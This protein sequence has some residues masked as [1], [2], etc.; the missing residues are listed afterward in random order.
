MAKKNVV[1]ISP[2]KAMQQLVEKN[3]ETLLVKLDPGM[4]EKKFRKKIK[5][6]G[7]IL[8]KGIKVKK[9]K[10]KTVATEP[11]ETAPSA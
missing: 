4:A 1:K 7:K 6:A 9:E 5:E 3:L 10:E 8:V 11:K 2:K